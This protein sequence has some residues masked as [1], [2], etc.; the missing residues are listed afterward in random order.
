MKSRRIV[1]VSVLAMAAATTAFAAES[2]QGSE[3]DEVVAY[4]QVKMTLADAIALA[5]RQTGGKAVEATLE[6][7]HGTVSFEV[8]IMKDRA[9]RKVTIDARTGQVV[10]S[11]AD[12]DHEEDGEQDDD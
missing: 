8:E 2:R 10:S 6:Q 3:A 4:E 9:F 11:N 12:R 1:V 7:E 5:E